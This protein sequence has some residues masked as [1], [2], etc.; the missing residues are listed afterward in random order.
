[1]ISAARGEAPYSNHRMGNAAD[2]WRPQVTWKGRDGRPGGLHVPVWRLEK[3]LSVDLCF[4]VTIRLEGTGEEF[5]G[6][7]LIVL[8]VFAEIHHGMILRTREIGGG[9]GGS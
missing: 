2:W 3:P 9:G 4:E 6:D 8:I 1:M 7:P 5:P